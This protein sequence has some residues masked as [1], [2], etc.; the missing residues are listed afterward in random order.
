M[1]LVIIFSGIIQSFYGNLQLLGYY[2]SNHSAFKI[3]GSFFN[4][5]PYAGFLTAVWPISLG[6]YL[7]KE[8]IENQCKKTFKNKFSSIQNMLI[9]F[10]LEYIPLV[11]IV[12]V[13]ILLPATRSR[14][15][16]LAVIIGSLILIEW[17]YHIIKKVFS[18]ISGLKK[19]ILLSGTIIVIG[20]SLF[21]IYNLKKGSSDGRLLVWNV[22]KEII[23]D[24]SVT[25]VGFDRFKAHY[26]NYQADYF[27][28]HGETMEAL[29]ADNTYYAFNEGFQFI[30]ENGFIGFLILCMV[31]FTIHRVKVEDKNNFLFFII[32]ATL[33]TIGVFALFSYPMQ[34]L[35]I[36]LIIV[37]IL[38]LLA[39]LDFGKY[40]IGR[41][42]KPYK[43]RILKTTFF[44]L[45][46]IGF[47]KGVTYTQT[48]GLSFKTW[49]NGL[50]LYK[51]GD[52]K[53]AVEEFKDVYSIF[54]NEG[55]FLMNYGK[56]LS[57]NKQDL[58]AIKVLERT[59]FHLN[60]TIIETALGD[61]YKNLKQYSKAEVAYIH[62]KNMIP[63]R[64]YPMYLLAKLYNESGENTKAIMIAKQ[65][66]EKD[67]KIPS[68]AIKEIQAEMKIMIHQHENAKI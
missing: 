65:I 59:K 40:H 23:K 15:S 33:L 39:S 1:S 37:I 34:L 24:N 30:V 12:S 20:I 2:P 7:F 47:L 51:Y 53:G 22:S 14:A 41:D 28:E 5:G 46:I 21:G 36:K 48:L 62:A 58:E 55:D 43:I 63:V 45:S 68:T 17:R 61:S 3:T 8:V 38:A 56:A 27:A 13:A 52:Y 6:M 44:I 29:V 31:I 42:I 10:T 64:F 4:P 49:E 67:I 16:W 18:K 25:G 57:M 54:K 9:K 26:M 32:K 11:G 60:T 35:P 50:T 19:T 66:L